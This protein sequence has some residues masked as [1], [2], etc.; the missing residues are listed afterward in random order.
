MRQAL[1]HLLS[2]FLAAI[3]FWVV[4]AVSGG[5]IAVAVGIA[6]AAGV[7][8][9]LVFRLRG[10]AINRMQWLTLGLVLVLGAASLA[11]QSARFM[12]AKPSIGHF[13]VAA[14]LLR[15]GWMSRYLPEIARQNIPESTIVTA[16]YV[17]AGVLAGIGVANLVVAA[18][19]SVQTWILFISVGSIGIKLAVL[20][21]QYLV[22]RTIVRR[23]LL[24][25]PL[26]A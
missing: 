26:P 15:R 6:M 21:G 8:Q 23:R 13:A 18:T 9:I 7:G 12:M 1:Q 3:L 2:D 22:F 19:A 5:N 25:P 20:A 4:Y 17:W 24:R 16:G 14:V 10:R 11:T